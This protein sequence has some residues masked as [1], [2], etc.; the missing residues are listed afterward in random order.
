VTFDDVEHLALASFFSP[1]NLMA[2]IK[3]AS[4]KPLLPLL[5]LGFGLP[6]LASAPAVAQTDCHLYTFCVGNWTVIWG[7]IPVYTETCREILG[8]FVR[9]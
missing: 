2:F 6:L 7:I 4:R 1:E 8:C 9:G 5:V 3:T